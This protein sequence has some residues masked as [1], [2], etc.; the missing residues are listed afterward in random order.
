MSTPSFHKDAH[1][2][3]ECKF[4]LVSKLESEARFR[5]PADQTAH[6][7]PRNDPPTGPPDMALCEATLETQ[8]EIYKNLAHVLLLVF[9]L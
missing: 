6:R 3:T 2:S 8:I 4:L 9:R 7:S 1:R 5:N